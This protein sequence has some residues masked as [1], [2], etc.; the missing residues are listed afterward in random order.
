MSNEDEEA[1]GKEEYVG[2]TQASIKD[3]SPI[4][5][6]EEVCE[7]DREDEREDTRLSDEKTPRKKLHRGTKANCRRRIRRIH[8]IFRILTTTMMMMTEPVP[9]KIPATATATAPAEVTGIM[10]PEEAPCNGCGS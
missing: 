1:D 10:V 7:Y 3:N 9:R 5:E 4:D 8:R 2:A 6:Y